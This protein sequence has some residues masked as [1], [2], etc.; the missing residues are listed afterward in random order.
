MC[1]TPINISEV[2]SYYKDGGDVV[3]DRGDYITA[4]RIHLDGDT[5]IADN[6]FE[7]DEIQKRLRRRKRSMRGNRDFC[8]IFLTNGVTL[9]TVP[10]CRATGGPWHLGG[11]R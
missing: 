2:L 3:R 1:H 8:P 4:Q 7:Y 10:T 9:E 5:T 6:I 11:T